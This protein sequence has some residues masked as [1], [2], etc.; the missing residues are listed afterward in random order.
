[1]TDVTIQFYT[2][3]MWRN[4]TREAFRYVSYVRVSP[5]QIS[6][7]RNVKWIPH[8][9]HVIQNVTH[10]AC[11]RRC[12]TTQNFTEPTRKGACVSSTAK[13][14]FLLEVDFSVRSSNWNVIWYLGEC[15]YLLLNV[16][17]WALGW[18]S[19]PGLSASECLALGLSLQ[20]V[21]RYFSVAKW[22]L[23]NITRDTFVAYINSEVVW[24]FKCW[25]MLHVVCLR[26]AER[27]GVRSRAAT[28]P[29]HL[30]YGIVYSWTLGRAV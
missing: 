28:S 21:Q 20:R 10:C 7:R 3:N 24:C 14:I 26:M 15:L 25:K 1:M 12:V 4:K 5:Y 19:T 11:C 30:Y 18:A 2:V 29:T 17:S 8:G 27:S 23:L 9:Q 16:W 6:K 13:F 22:I